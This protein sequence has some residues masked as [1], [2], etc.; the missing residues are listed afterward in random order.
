MRWAGTTAFAQQPR[1]IEAGLAGPHCS[2]SDSL[3]SLT[4]L[5][6]GNAGEDSGQAAVRSGRGK[7]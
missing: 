3:Y 6:N 7:K 4:E 1:T 5:A 2:G